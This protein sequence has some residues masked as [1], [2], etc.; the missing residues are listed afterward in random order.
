[1]LKNYDKVSQLLST[2]WISD[3]VIWSYLD[4]INEKIL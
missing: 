3:D 1:M 2:N 4:I